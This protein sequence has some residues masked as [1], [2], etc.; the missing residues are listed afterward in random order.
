MTI[1]IKYII[2]LAQIIVS[3]IKICYNLR[4][5]VWTSVGN[6]KR[7]NIFNLI[8]NNA[9]NKYRNV[10]VSANVKIKTIITI[11]YIIKTNNYLIKIN[12]NYDKKYNNNPISNN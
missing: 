1:Q 7:I 5:L 8:I 9:N 6:S 10:N 3:I 2:P 4:I 11:N 12:N